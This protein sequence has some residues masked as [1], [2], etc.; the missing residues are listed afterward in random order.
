MVQTVIG[1]VTTEVQVPFTQTFGAGGGGSGAPS[2][3]SGSIGLGTLTGEVGVV[4]T[5]DAKGGA[6][7]RG[8]GE[9]WLGM[10]LVVGGGLLVGGW[11][12]I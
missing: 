11:L 7:R 1:G 10:S 5:A 4:K 3:M 8:G 2:V 6:V 12:V 9:G